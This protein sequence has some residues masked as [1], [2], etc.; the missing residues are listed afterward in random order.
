MKSYWVVYNIPASTTKLPKNARSIGQ[1]GINDMR[2]NAYEPMCS[3][4]PGAKSYHITVYALS[5][6]LTLAPNTADRVKLLEAV[7][8]SALA[9]GTYT[10]RYERQ[11]QN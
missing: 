5:K 8:A 11:R 9:E 10:Y 1:V 2:R 3:K 6:E 4:G 7:K